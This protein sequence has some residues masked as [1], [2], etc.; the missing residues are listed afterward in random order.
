MTQLRTGSHWLREETGRW[1]K[2]EREQR[3]CPY[4]AQSDVRVVK[5]VEHMVFS[6]P[7]YS[8]VRNRYQCLDFSE[9]NLHQFLQQDPIK[10]ASFSTACWQQ[11]NELQAEA[12][13]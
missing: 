10:L 6:C 12:H 4:C 9:I 3:V 5:D 2:L 13:P 1:E 8:S 11:H 7:S